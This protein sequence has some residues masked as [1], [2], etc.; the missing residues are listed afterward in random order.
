MKSSKRSVRPHDADVKLLHGVAPDWM[1]LVAASLGLELPAD[2]RARLA[3]GAAATLDAE[4][5]GVVRSRSVRAPPLSLRSGTTPG[6]TGLAALLA[7]WDAT[8]SDA[9]ES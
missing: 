6:G 2:V 5:A 7:D 4:L 9:R 8:Q 3:S 1:S